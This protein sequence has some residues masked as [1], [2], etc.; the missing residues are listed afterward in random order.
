VQ[1]N[2]ILIEKTKDS[3][4]ELVENKSKFNLKYQKDFLDIVDKIVSE[5]NLDWDFNKEF[6]ASELTYNEE[7]EGQKELKKMSEK[8]IK[9]AG[10]LYWMLNQDFFKALN[11]SCK[12]QEG[13]PGTARELIMVMKQNLF[14]S[15][16]SKYVDKQIA[17]LETSGQGCVKIK[18]HRALRFAET[19]KIDHEGEHMIFG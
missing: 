7:K 11:F 17:N 8:V 13:I 14:A 5:K 18:R 9:Q 4:N 12:E 3:W 16:K 2:N 1:K 19:G 10:T 6:N 15:V